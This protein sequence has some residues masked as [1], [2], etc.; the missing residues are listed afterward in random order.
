MPP[1]CLGFA[2]KSGT[3]PIFG[4]FPASRCTAS[5]R[6]EPVRIQWA[7]CKACGTTYSVSL[8]TPGELGG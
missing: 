8:T 2:G 6:Q 3:L 7:H 1:A 4:A 5:S